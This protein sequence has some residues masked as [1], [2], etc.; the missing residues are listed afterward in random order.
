MAQRQIGVT[1]SPDNGSNPLS[2]SNL[3]NESVHL[4]ENSIVGHPGP[5]TVEENDTHHSISNM[6]QSHTLTPSRGGTL[7]KRQSLSRKNS[8]KRSGSRKNSRPASVKSL[9]FA[10]D[11][12]GHESEMNSAFFTP[13]PTTGSP[14][15]I[16]ANRFQGRLRYAEKKG[17][18]IKGTCADTSPRQF[19][20]R[21]LK[22]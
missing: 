1:G 22:I 11:V 3:H 8:L 14:T 6:S 21:C 9:N 10:D 18:I 20:V 16:L 7:K 13:V 19:G 12:V 15:D 2:H 5:S 17:V 4:D